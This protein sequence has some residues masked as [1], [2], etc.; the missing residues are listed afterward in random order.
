MEC[1]LN[2]SFVELSAVDA[3]DVNGGGWGEFA[4]ALGGGVCVAI[5]PAVGVATAIGTAPVIGPASIAAGVAATGSV[6]A[7][8]FNLL[9]SACN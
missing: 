5:S 2:N 3:S 1:V 9:D 7:V 6:A 4:Q 8:G